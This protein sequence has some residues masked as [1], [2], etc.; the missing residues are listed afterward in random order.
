MKRALLFILAFFLT[1]MPAFSFSEIDDVASIEAQTKGEYKKIDKDFYLKGIKVFDQLNFADE[2]KDLAAKIYD[3]F[4]KEY[5]FSALE[6]TEQLT[7]SEEKKIL[8]GLIFASLNM[9][10]SAEDMLKDIENPVLE[11]YKG[12][13]HRENMIETLPFYGLL[14]QD[15]NDKYDLDYQ[16]WGINNTKNIK[17][18]KI[19][20][21]YKMI[22]YTSSNLSFDGCLVN[23]IKFS[24]NARPEPKWEY[25]ASVAGKFFEQNGSPLLL[26]DIWVKYH[27]NDFVSLKLGAARDSVEQSYITAVG[28]VIDNDFTGR[29]G[30]N[31]IFIETKIRMKKDFYL[32]ARGNAGFY[33][34]SSL[35][36]NFYFSGYVNIGKR[37][38]NNPHNPYLQKIDFDITSYNLG[39]RDDLLNIYGQNGAEYGGYFSPR[40]YNATA[41][42]IRFEGEYKRL[43]YGLKGFIGEQISTDDNSMTP[44]FGVSPYI[45]FKINNRLY[46]KATYSFSEFADIKSQLFAIGL[47]IRI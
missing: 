9:M 23:Y 41:A 43:S 7:N 45:K 37:I 16:K 20:L 25:R 11:A 27:F 34:A 12:S 38:Y 21:D 33:N 22:Q 17:D 1:L 29:A 24:T 4:E 5:Y 35:P 6:K 26:G 18:S 8:K 19:E 2:D 30:N 3:D 28:S 40:Y 42:N 14:N 31:K 36:E 10:N 32:S 46:L 39:F 44:T 15:L 13:L 47:L